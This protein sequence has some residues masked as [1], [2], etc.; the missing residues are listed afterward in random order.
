[1]L[2]IL[3][4]LVKLSL[5]MSIMP[6]MY[7]VTTSGWLPYLTHLQNFTKYKI[8]QSFSSSPYYSRLAG[9]YTKL[10]EKEMGAPVYQKMDL[11]DKKA[12][13]TY[14]FRKEGG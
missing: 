7:Q 12:E 11:F 14:L 3:V 13:Q 1:M 5:A 10:V 4:I 9:V 2:M 8:K 6:L